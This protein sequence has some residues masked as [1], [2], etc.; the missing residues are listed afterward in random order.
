MALKVTQIRGLVGAHKKQKDAMQALGLRKIHQSR[1]HK[2]NAA[3]RG[4]IQVVSHLVTV[5]EV[6]GE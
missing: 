4:N 6:E 2:D 1:V 5:E 3:V